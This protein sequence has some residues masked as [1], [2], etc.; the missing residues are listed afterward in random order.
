MYKPS[1]YLVKSYFPIYLPTNIY[2]LL[3]KSTSI[4]HRNGLLKKKKLKSLSLYLSL[5]GPTK[6]DEQIPPVIQGYCSANYPMLLPQLPH[7]ENCIGR[8]KTQINIMRRGS[9]TGFSLP[10]TCMTK[11][12]DKDLVIVL[13]I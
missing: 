10:S 2:D 13:R 3:V 12:Y 5:D 11:R 7:L 1:T 8:N 4:R 6:Y 9:K